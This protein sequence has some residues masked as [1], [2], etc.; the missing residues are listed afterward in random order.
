MVFVIGQRWVSNTESELGLGIVTEYEGRRVTLSFPA[1]GEHRTYA[2]DNAPVTRVTYQVGDRVCNLDELEICIDNLSEHEGLISYSGLTAAGESLLL[3]EIELDCFVHFSAPQDRLFA[4]QIDSLKRYKMR[5]QTLRQ[6]ARLSQGEAIGLLGPRVQ[7]LPHQLF[8][9][10]EVGQR[11]APRVLLAD[12][13]GLG[14]TIEAG[15]ILHRQLITG[16]A[17]RALIVVPDS[18]VH[19]WLVEM[20]RRF[21]L[22]FTLLDENRC[23]AIEQEN[24]LEDESEFERDV[25][26][27]LSTPSSASSHSYSNASNST[28]TDMVSNPFESTQLVLCS[29]TFI[30]SERRLAQAAAADW[31]LLLVDE[32]HHLTWSETEPSAQYQAIELLA[33]RAGGVLLL[34]ATPEQL[35]IEGHF[36]RLRLLDPD[37]YYDLNIFIEEEKQYQPV[38]ALVQSLMSAI[39]QSAC[40]FDVAQLQALSHYFDEK[41][42]TAWSNIVG[43]DGDGAAFVHAVAEITRQLLD[44]HGTGR[45]LFRN[46]RSNVN[47]FPARCLIEHPLEPAEGWSAVALADTELTDLLQP[48]SQ[49]GQDWLLRDTR[50]NWLCDFLKKDRRRKILLICAKAN[51]AEVLE[52]HLNLR[53]GT[54]SA[55]FHEHMSLLERDRAAA[56]FADLEEGA[57]ILVCSE[58]GSE[59]RN[60]QFAHD[61]IM[62]DLPLNPDLLEQRIGRLD[63][64]GQNQ[65]VKIHVPFYINSPAQ[66]L[67]RWFDAGIDAFSHSS[68]AG[69]VLKN[70]FSQRLESCLRAPENIEEFDVLVQDSR[71]RFEFLKSELQRGR[72][73]LLELN[74]CNAEAAEAVVKAV[75][76]ASEDIDLDGYMS[77]AFDVFGVDQDV[78]GEKS[79]ILHPSDHMP[80]QEFPGLPDTGLTATFCRETALARDDIHFL[81]WEHPMVRGVMDAVVSTELGNTAVATVK[82][83]PL[84][85]GTLLL[86]TTYRLSCPA[87]RQLQLFRY[88]PSVIGRNLTDSNGRDLTKALPAD[89]FSQLLQKVP[90]QTAQGL[91]KHARPQLQKMLQA[92][93]LVEQARLPEIIAAAIE[94]MTE[95]QRQ[96]L[97]RLTALAKVNPSIRQQELVW[98]RQETE[99]LTEYLNKAQLR[100]DSVRVII[101]T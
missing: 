45:V 1:A 23:D 28:P 61:L 96:E 70:E 76:D 92:V 100:L 74:S 44:R 31:D 20:L 17:R 36:A 91:V 34:T 13:V 78:H 66:Q 97:Q 2:I 38:N 77:L 29:L 99:M 39:D 25:L 30:Q 12:E 27:E 7:L 62:F 84:K 71:Q 33:Q 69:L 94:K 56:Y 55:V 57:Q 58:I 86:E 65:D 22:P 26:T 88:L 8:I 43:L 24:L 11:A 46:T 52:H 64:I 49:L 40:Q 80:F 50:V 67:L 83:G 19:Q 21:N 89:K 9:A 16:Q 3:C 5:E 85:P 95:Q 14:K 4:G 75:V 15:M 54:R 48:E 6:Q 47:G 37:R 42:L 35:G 93:E 53:T 73:Q 82:L 101:A 63:R 10:S 32:A 87:P 68:V 72:D 51:T 90:R 60:F 98:L 18:L 59:G 79:I 41:Q 81:T